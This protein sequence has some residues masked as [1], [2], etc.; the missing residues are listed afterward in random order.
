[1]PPLPPALPPHPFQRLG[2]RLA[3]EALRLLRKLANSEVCLLL[4]GAWSTESYTPDLH[5]CSMGA[6]ALC[7][8]SHLALYR[9]SRPGQENLIPTNDGILLLLVLLLHT[10]HRLSAATHS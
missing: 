1:M 6:G 9:H 2:E 10:S 3:A 7:I 8:P 5:H 4:A